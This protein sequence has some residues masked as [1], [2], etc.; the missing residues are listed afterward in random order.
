MGICYQKENNSHKRKRKMKKLLIAVII[1]ILPLLSHTAFAQRGGGPPEERAEK[2]TAMMKEFLDLTDEQ[3][4]KVEEINLKFAKSNEELREKHRGN[5]EAIIAAFRESEQLKEEALAQALT[6]EQ[7]G[8][9]REK[10]EEMRSQR[11]GRGSR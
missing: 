7:L 9:L 6:E 8:K 10:K 4:P 3:L 2:Q 1:F 5:R 11:R